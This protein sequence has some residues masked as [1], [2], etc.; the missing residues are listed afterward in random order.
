MRARRVV[1]LACA[2]GIVILHALLGSIAVVRSESIQPAPET[3]PDQWN[4]PKGG[5]PC[6]L[7]PA[8]TN[9]SIYPNGYHNGCESSGCSTARPILG[10]DY[11]APKGTKIL[12]PFDGKVAIVAVDFMGNTYIRIVSA[13]GKWEFGSL[14]GDYSVKAGQKVKAGQEVGTV[15][16]HGQAGGVNHSHTYFLN[17]KSWRNTDNHDKFWSCYNSQPGPEPTPAPTPEPAKIYNFS[18]KAQKPGDLDYQH[19]IRAFFGWPTSGYD[20]GVLNGMALSSFEGYWEIPA[21]TTKSV[22]D[23]FGTEK[24]EEG[25]GM[26]IPSTGGI[27]DG[28]CN[29]ASFI[30]YVSHSEGLGVNRDKPTHPPVPGVP[31]AWVATVCIPSAKYQCPLADVRISNPYN[32]PVRLHWKV[33]GDNIDLWVEKVGVVQVPDGGLNIDWLRVAELGAALLV[34]LLIIYFFL[35]RRPG[36]VVDAAIWTADNSRH[37][38]GILEEAFRIAWGWNIVVFTA[39]VVFIPQLMEMI[40]VVS[41]QWVKGQ[42]LIWNWQIVVLVIALVVNMFVRALT[43]YRQPKPK[44]TALVRTKNGELVRAEVKPIRTRNKYWWFWILI[45]LVYIFAPDLMPGPVD[46]LLVA[47]ITGYLSFPPHIK[48]KLKWVFIIL[49][50][51]LVI[52]VLVFAIPALQNQVQQLGQ[53]QIIHDILTNNIVQAI[54]EHF[55]WQPPAPSPTPTPTPT[56]GP[57]PGQD[58]SL[59]DKVPANVRRWCEYIDKYS[60]KHNIDSDLTA[61]LIQ[62]ESRGNPKAR[63]SCDAIGLMQVMP[64]DPSHRA[65]VACNLDISQFVNRPT[66]QELLDPMINV[67]TG[68]NI[69][70]GYIKKYGSVRE[71]LFHYG[72]AGVGYSY[73]DKVISV[74]ESYRPHNGR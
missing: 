36:M 42:T 3:A 22:N 58:C 50:T 27:G 26:V 63:S 72:P 25:Q 11:V 51:I 8:G 52:I 2:L 9:W 57:S 20:L 15:N 48:K 24:Y 44:R 40:N 65:I 56:P 43:I 6:F 28:S 31:Q 30:S 71:A 61:A 18:I 55:G 33:S 16:K 32:Y 64:S 54:L 19:N 41:R 12:S 23:F 38:K 62:V 5:G 34:L 35:K 74:Y 68:C 37:V 4:Y 66:I 10:F 49:V 46:D 45:G 69:L 73:A 59:S 47:T 13:D 53:L 7:F 17:L 60:L 67:K 70:G 29:A 1:L 39:A 21:K 14:H